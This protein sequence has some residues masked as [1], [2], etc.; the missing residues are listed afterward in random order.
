M[1]VLTCAVLLGCK[2]D[3]TVAADD[4]TSLGPPQD[5]IACPAGTTMRG[6]SPPEGNRVW[7]ETPAG[8]SQGPFLSWYPEGQKKTEGFFDKGDASGRWR[9]WYD[10]GQLRSVGRY[11]GGERHGPW[12]RYGRDGSELPELPRYAEAYE[13]VRHVIGVPACDDFLQRY[14]AC[15]DDKAPE[16]L[17]GQLRAAMAAMLDGWKTAAA[18]SSGRASL[19]A[20]CKAAREAVAKSTAAWGCEF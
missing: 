17:K 7:C 16:A 15:I 1:R 13:P 19:S 14:T 8:V 6:R 11:E 5:P 20:A 18:S 4:G 9:T 3:P 2:P 10:N 12:Q